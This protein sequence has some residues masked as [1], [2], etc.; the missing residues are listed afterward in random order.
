MRMWRDFCPADILPFFSNFMALSLSWCERLCVVAFYPCFSM[1]MCIHIVLARYSLA[2]T[3][4]AS[5][6]LFVFSFASSTCRLFLP[7]QMTSLCLCNSS[8]LG[9]PRTTRPPTSSVLPCNQ[10][11]V[12]TCSPEFQHSSTLGR[13]L[14]CPGPP[15]YIR[16]RIDTFSMLWNTSASFP[17]KRLDLLLI[18]NG[19]CLAGVA[20]VLL[21]PSPD[22]VMASCVKRV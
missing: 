7:S 15:E 19:S 11:Q 12:C 8:C 13:A 22:S 2:P 14:V 3:S 16:A 9:E 5:V 1:N 10:L 4:S 18:L 20:A 21:I 6:K 17:S